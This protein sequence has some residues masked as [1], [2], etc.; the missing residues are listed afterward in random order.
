[1]VTL[2]SDVR[3]SLTLTRLTWRSP[4][5]L[6]VFPSSSRSICRRR[7]RA[8]RARTSSLSSAF[9]SRFHIRSLPPPWV[10]LLACFTRAPCILLSNSP[11]VTLRAPVTVGEGLV[12]SVII[13][14]VRPRSSLFA[15]AKYSYS[16]PHLPPLSLSQPRPLRSTCFA[17][18]TRH[19]GLV[20]S[21][22]DPTT[23]SSGI[24]SRIWVPAL[25]QKL[26]GKLGSRRR[27]V[28]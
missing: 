26:P 24:H 15:T 23:P 14:I 11:R 17:W 5:S 21:I 19:R 9:V 7:V 10:C 8:F 20:S 27:E 16:T 6:L 4:I 2:A 28:K 1:M 18:S 3:L 22:P 13:L 25:A 12:P